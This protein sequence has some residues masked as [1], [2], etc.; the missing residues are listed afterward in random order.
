MTALNFPLVALGTALTVAV[1]AF[2]VRRLI[3][4][5]LSTMRTLLAGLIA[6]FTAS[7]IITAIGGPTVGQGRGVL[8]GHHGRDD[9]RPARWP[10]RDPDR[11]P[12]RLLRVL[13]PGGRR[14][15]G[16]PRAGPR[17]PPGRNV[18]G[19]TMDSGAASL[20]T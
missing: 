12:V 16:R 7:P 13:P 9:D 4:L 14:D 11:Q 6:F 8:P 10:E 2:G 1:F 18:S 19:L 15:P 20:G 17:V 5:P 3:G